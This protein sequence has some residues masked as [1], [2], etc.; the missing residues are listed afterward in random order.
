MNEFPE[1]SCA[2]EVEAKELAKNYNY[3]YLSTI[4]TPVR[5]EGGGGEID[6]IDCVK[7]GRVTPVAR[8]HIRR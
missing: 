8:I 6:F 4:Y 5:R 7:V 1:L 3:D 2:S